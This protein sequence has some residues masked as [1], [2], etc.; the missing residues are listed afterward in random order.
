MGEADAG[1]AAFSGVCGWLWRVIRWWLRFPSV[2]NILPQS[3]H[4]KDVVAD[5]VVVT[6]GVMPAEAPAGRRDAESA[7]DTNE[8][9]I[10]CPAEVTTLLLR[11]IVF[12]GSLTG[13]APAPPL[14]FASPVAAFFCRPVSA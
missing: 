12:A 4:V 10:S 2:R 1:G 9:A 7:S 13:A 3:G 11:M 8:A 14:C 5:V 6:F